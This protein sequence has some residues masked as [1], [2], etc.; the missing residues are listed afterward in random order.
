MFW[1][2][3]LG[4]WSRPTQPQSISTD[5]GLVWLVVQQ[6]LWWRG[7][8]WDTLHTPGRHCV[9]DSKTRISK[10]SKLPFLHIVVVVTVVDEHMM[11]RD[12]SIQTVQ[13]A[14]SILRTS[15][16]FDKFLW[17]SWSFFGYF[18]FHNFG[19]TTNRWPGSGDKN[20]LIKRLSAQ[21]GCSEEEAS[22]KR[23]EEMWRDGK[24]M[25]S[26]KQLD[27]FTSSFCV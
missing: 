25:Q 16:D 14:A 27:K 17:I 8:W 5:F 4:S 3:I 2:S 19:K 13:A 6:L 22:P 18:G 7:T 21:Y 10:M 23:C 1:F 20:L 26:S 24:S 15:G 11:H 12:R 9:K